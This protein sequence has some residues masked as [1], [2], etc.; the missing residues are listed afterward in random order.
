MLF[1]CLLVV[2]CVPDKGFRE[3]FEKSVKGYNRMLRWQEVVA[4]GYLYMEPEGREKFMATA[5]AM[6]KRGVSITDFRI[7]TMDSLSD[8][9]RGD[10]LVEFDYYSLPS[11]RIKTLT[12]KQEWAYRDVDDTK[13]WRVKSPL[14]PF[15]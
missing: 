11:F 9:K 12:Y 4:A 13:S 7:L 2:S 15:D 14:P 3:E 6:G 8:K 1:C 10:A 5:D